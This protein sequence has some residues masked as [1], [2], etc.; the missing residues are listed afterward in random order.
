[1]E[2]TDRRVLSAT[3]FEEDNT[4]EGIVANI[5]SPICKLVRVLSSI[6]TEEKNGE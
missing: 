5:M 2:K 4:E 1:M 3:L 6:Q